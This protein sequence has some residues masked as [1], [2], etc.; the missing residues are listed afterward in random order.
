MV[1]DDIPEPAQEE[2]A[3]KVIE[4]IQRDQGHKIIAM[5]Q[6]SVVQSERISELERDN[7]RLRGVLD[8]AS[9]RVTRFQRRKTMPNTRY[10]ATMTYE[11]INKLIARQV[12]E[13]LEARDAARNLEH[14]AKGW[15]EQED[16]N[17]N[18]YE[19]GNGGG[20]EMEE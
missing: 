19:G 5:G 1:S 14:L 17:G 8:V 16:E 7:T 4:S 9:Q 20:N 11:G 3:I 13:A 10:G 6:Q 2:G 15:D 18:D 12:A